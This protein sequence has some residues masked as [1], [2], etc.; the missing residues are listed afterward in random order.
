[1]TCRCPVG[2]PALIV[3][4]LSIPA[5]A[6]TTGTDWTHGTTLNVFAGAGIDDSDATPLVGA[7]VGWELT[8]AI[9]IEGSGY[10]L[11]RTAGTDAFAAAL[12]LQAALAVGHTAVPFLEAGVG[13][14]RASFD[15]MGHSVPGF[16]RRRLTAGAPGPGS[17]T[18]FTDPSFVLGGGV[19]VFVTRHISFRPGIEVMIVRRHAQNC[20]VTTAAVHVAYHFEDHPVTPSRTLNDRYA[21]GVQGL[22]GSI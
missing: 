13:L 11:E 15:P 1:M 2:W 22:D 19:N 16:Y 8:P 10:W 4:A 7:S 6:Q 18:T 17:M 9:A 21:S 20:G 5:S 3:F 12:K 14:Y